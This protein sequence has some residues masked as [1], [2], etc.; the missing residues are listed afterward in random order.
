MNELLDLES[1]TSR[2]MLASVLDNLL[3]AHAKE[4]AQ[5]QRDWLEDEYNIAPLEMWGATII[6]ELIDPSSVDYIG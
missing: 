3:V 6:P 1:N 5:K 4:L 2:G